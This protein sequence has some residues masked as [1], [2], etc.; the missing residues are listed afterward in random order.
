VTTAKLI[1]L[2]AV[3]FFTSVISVVT[4][5]T[6]LITVPVMIGLGIEAHTAIATNMLALI[7]MSAGGSLPFVRSNAIRSTYL[8]LSILLTVIGSGSG[9]ILLLTVPLRA[10]QLTIAVAMI[11]VT[12]FTLAKRDLGL[13]ISEK[14]ASRSAVLAGYGLTFL[15]AVYGGFFSGGYVTVLTA[16]FVVFFGMTFLHSVATTKVINVFSSAVATCVFLWRGVVDVKL[17]IV[18]GIV[19]FFGALLGARIALKLHPVWLRR[20]FITAVLGLAMKMLFR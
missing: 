18:L 10:L 2:I 7:F 19:M 14:P 4:G 13:S 1:T 3:F 5:S 20:I 12:I 9:A 6:S 15:F 11:A 8:P 16:T 17:G